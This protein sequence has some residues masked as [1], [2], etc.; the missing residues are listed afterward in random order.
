MHS[1][2]FVSGDAGA[3]WLGWV[4]IG[5][6]FLIIYLPQF[7]IEPFLNGRKNKIRSSKRT[8]P[9]P[10]LLREYGKLD[11][12]HTGIV[13]THIRWSRLPIVDHQS[14]VSDDVNLEKT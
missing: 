2:C 1:L 12:I 9:L 7:P 10:Q 4:G 13:F 8:N 6:R 14:Q 11:N 3:V 5:E